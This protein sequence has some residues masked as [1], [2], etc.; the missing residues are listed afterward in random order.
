VTDGVTDKQGIVIATMSSTIA[1]QKTVTATFAGV[2]INTK[3]DFQLCHGGLFSA[4]A[5]IKVGNYPER[6]S[7]ATSTETTSLICHFELLR[8]QREHPVGNRQRDV[9]AKGHYNAG[10]AL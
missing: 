10:N 7:R 8:R 1:E 4:P 9:C 3:V 2:S 6:W 5:S